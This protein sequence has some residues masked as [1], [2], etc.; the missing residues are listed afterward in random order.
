MDEDDMDEDSGL[1]RTL[2]YDEL[3][4]SMLLGRPT[5]SRRNI[6]PDWRVQLRNHGNSAVE[7]VNYLFQIIDKSGLQQHGNRKAIG[8]DT[9]EL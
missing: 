7:T 8:R 4:Q 1:S 9:A 6:N 5:T 3:Q 2:T